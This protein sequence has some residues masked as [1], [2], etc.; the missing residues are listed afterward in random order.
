MGGIFAALCTTNIPQG[1]ILEGLRR[2]MYR[3]YDGAG[4]AILR[5]GSIEVRKA[6]GHLLN[7]SKTVDLV[8]I[9]ST[10]ALGHVRYA[11]RGWPVYEN[12]HPL[13]D[14]NK[15]IA[16]VGDGI[17]DNYEEVKSLL[18]KKGHAFA[19]RTDTEVS[20]HLLEEYLKSGYDALR[21]LLEVARRLE[22]NYALAFLNAMDGSIYV[23]QHGQPLVI[24]IGNSCVY[25]S[26]DIPSLS[27]F[28]ETAYVLNDY[29]IGIVST[30]AIELYD[31]KTGERLSLES[32]QAK[33][34]KYP[35]EYVDKGGYP[36]Y[37]I[38]EI[39]ET[40]SALINTTHS[41]ME[42]YLRL[43]AMIVHG[44]KEVYAIGTGTSLHAAMVAT[45][46][47]SE[48]AGRVI[49][50]VSAAEFPYSVLENVTTGTV[51]IA[52]SQSGETFDVIASVKQAKQRG[53]VIVGVV[54]NVGSRLAL[55]SN[56]YLP[57]GA[58]PEM[59]VPATKTFSST[60]AALLMLASYTGMYSGRVTS[61][62]YWGVVEQI[63]ATAKTLREL[64]PM[65]E[66]KITLISQEIKDVENAYVVSSG[67]THP[68][69]IEGAL[70]LKEAALI[71]AEGI[72]LGE[73]RHGPLSIVNPRFPVILIEPYE[74]V[75]QPLYIRVLKELEHRNVRTIAIELETQKTK[76]TSIEVP[77]VPR[78]LYPIV[79]AVA[80]Q[81]LAYHLGAI[82][83]LPVDTP[84][85]LAK[86][87]TA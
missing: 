48:L 75:A 73:L 23:I 60:L 30:N 76:Y 49:I 11:S 3:G 15:K 65:L 25:L 80:L 33:R 63:R 4:V 83:N 61:K 47:F 20:V 10:V 74:E 36:H 2:L 59:A 9:D 53:A 85:G 67:I 38:K 42:K 27:G 72:Q 52:I 54:N 62:E 69:A 81:L 86:T 45:Y 87:I 71:H 7:V 24:G 5:G 51:I 14:C 78:H 18:E 17:I 28:A 66:N 26:S 55:E 56:V 8:N 40:P 57:V 68:I 34:V 16:V 70:K 37:M 46:Y 41:I 39:Y 1:A 13:L 6:P 50:P 22:G 58:G 29:T 64:I 21:S 44:A 19:S 43:A 32:L 84:P 35:P 77:R 31:V 12:T 79:A 82:K